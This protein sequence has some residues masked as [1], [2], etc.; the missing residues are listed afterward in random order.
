MFIYCHFFTLL[1][2]KEEEYAIYSFDFDEI[3]EKELSIR[4]GAE[5][6]YTHEMLG[7]RYDYGARLVA[8]S[9]DGF[10]L[11]VLG[12]FWSQMDLVGGNIELSAIRI[13]DRFSYK[14]SLGANI[15][16]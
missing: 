7:I 13:D 4:G 16:F 10:Y 6:L 8:S 11:S 12:G 5:M 1:L 9:Y 3:T 14:V 15:K 2:Y